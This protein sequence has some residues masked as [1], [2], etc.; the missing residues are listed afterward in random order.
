[1]GEYYIAHHGIKGMKWGVRRWQNAD[2]SYNAAGRARYGF[3]DGKT[4]SGVKGKNG[5][6][7]SS[8]RG[9]SAANSLRKTAESVGGAA[10]KVLGNKNFQKA[11]IGVGVGAA[12]LGT[13][14]ALHKTGADKA[15]AETLAKAK[16]TTID[17]IKNTKAKFDTYVLG[18]NEVDTV[19]KS[20]TEFSRVQTDKDFKG[21]A[22]YA[23]YKNH[24]VNEYQGLFGK[25]LKD[26]ALHDAQN[27]GDAAGIEKAKHMKV[28]RVGL[29][30][31]KD[32]NVPSDANAGKITAD[33]LKDK[34]FSDNLSESLSNARK[35]MRRPGQQALLS[36][37]Q[38]IMKKAPEEMTDADKK[39]LYKGLNLTLTYH[40]DSDVKVQDK[41]YS[42]LKEKGY[43]ALVDVNDQQ[44]SSYHA[45]RPMIVFDTSATKV[46]SSEEITND[47]INKLY[48]KHNAERILKEAVHQPLTAIPNEIK[49][50][51]ND[52]ISGNEYKEYAHNIIGEA[53]STAGVAAGASAGAAYGARK[54]SKVRKRK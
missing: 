26:R 46:R 47:K 14:Y 8:K 10:K 21:Y 1:M 44:Y 36:D 13:A 34:D 40:N 15:I 3:G 20:D 31:G 9:S 16:D 48:N 49:A 6:S 38:R 43:G 54:A 24:D 41:F 23:T 39:T 12:A 53:G 4:Y 42:A 22:Y 18:K 50:F 27:A 33:L 11:A 52:V 29:N 45:K 51:G 7:G 5:G 19:V 2:G 25:N 32:L 35:N 30:A 37:A 28:F 17:S